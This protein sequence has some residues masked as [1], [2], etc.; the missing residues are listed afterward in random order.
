MTFKVFAT[1]CS[2]CLFSNDKIVD[3][4]AKA[5]VLEECEQ[6]DT[7]F[8]CHK[9]TMDGGDICCHTFYKLAEKRGHM[10]KLMAMADWLGMVEFVPLPEGEKLIP[11]R[12]WSGE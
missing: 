12:E 6:N 3:D 7:H 5:K 4:E 1:S 8:I 10:P 9:A 11:A 2:N